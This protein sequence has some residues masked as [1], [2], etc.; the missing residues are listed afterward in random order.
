MARKTY[1]D[2]FRAKAVKALRERGQK[3]VAEVAEHLGVAPNLLHKWN[4]SIRAGSRNG[5]PT[6]ERKPAAKRGSK[7]VSNLPKLQ[8]IQDSLMRIQAATMAIKN[9]LDSVEGLSKTERQQVLLSIAAYDL[10]Q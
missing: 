8:T 6:K 7:R 1:D 5:I 9:G 4:K 2:T 10:L 3:T